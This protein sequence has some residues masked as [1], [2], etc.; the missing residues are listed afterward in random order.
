MI[1][2]VGINISEVE[3]FLKKNC[4]APNSGNLLVLG[5]QNGGRC[6]W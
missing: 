1:H 4:P 2:Y 3:L 6:D 5:G